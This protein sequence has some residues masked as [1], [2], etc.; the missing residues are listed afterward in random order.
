VK[1]GRTLLITLC[2]KPR[3]DEAWDTPAFEALLQVV[4]EVFISHR[5]RYLL[6][7]MDEAAGSVQKLHKV[8]L[9]TLRSIGCKVRASWSCAMRGAC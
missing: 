4:K 8:C 3:S 9:C 2:S 5:H 6:S 7:L 1:C